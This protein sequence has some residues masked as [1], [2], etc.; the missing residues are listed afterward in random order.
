MAYITLPAE[1]FVLSCLRDSIT[2]RARA[3]ARIPAASLQPEDTSTGLLFC[4]PPQKK[5]SAGVELRTP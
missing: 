1:M 2:R 5:S 3:P 4:P